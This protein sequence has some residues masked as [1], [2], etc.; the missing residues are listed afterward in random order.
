[1][2]QSNLIIM[3]LRIYPFLLEYDEIGYL[4]GIHIWCSDLELYLRLTASPR[5]LA[6][7]TL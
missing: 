5:H 1:M 7:Y 3:R 4:A 2:W 6:I